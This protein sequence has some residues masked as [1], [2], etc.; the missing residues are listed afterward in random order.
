MPTAQYVNFETDQLMVKYIADTSTCGLVKVTVQTSS[1]KPAL[2]NKQQISGGGAC[3][4]CYPS[5]LTVSKI[6]IIKEKLLY[7]CTLKQTLALSNI[8]SVRTA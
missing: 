6:L 8:H 7:I 1:A 4:H 5:E 2:L 3:L